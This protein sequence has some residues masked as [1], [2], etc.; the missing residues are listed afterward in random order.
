[1]SWIITHSDSKLKINIDNRVASF[2]A[3]DWE[4]TT[5]VQF[6]VTD[7]EGASDSMTVK[8]TINFPS[9]VDVISMKIP[10]AF[11][12]EQNYPN[13]FNP[14][15]IIPFAL[16]ERSYVKLVL[17]DVLGNVVKEIARGE[18]EAGHHEVELNA[19][20]LA[21]GVYFYKI[22]AGE[23]VDVKKLVVMK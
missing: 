9:S 14:T 18:Y 20:D 4:G 21:A 8:F 7:P 5:N 1:M 19:A 16:P 6:K 3:P 17:V 22:E 15:S 12:I 13:P 10:N 2:T 23:F 11:C